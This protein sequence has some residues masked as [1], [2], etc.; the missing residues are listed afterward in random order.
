MYTVRTIIFDLEWSF[1]G[2]S[3]ITT[4][5]VLSLFIRAVIV[6]FICL[7][8]GILA[9][10][11]LWDYVANLQR[12]CRMIYNSE[13]F[14]VNKLE[15]P[16]M[17]R[18]ETAKVKKEMAY[19]PY[20]Y[21]KQKRGMIE[22]TVRLDGSKFHQ[23]GVFTNLTETLEQVYFLSVTDMYERKGYYTYCLLQDSSKSR[24]SIEEVNPVRY[25]IPLTK[26]LTW[27][28]AKIP[29]ALI[30]GGTGGGKSFFLNVLIRGFVKMGADIRI[31]DP[32]NS[33]LS[34][35]KTIL[36][37][38]ATSCTGIMEML[39][40][41]VENMEGRYIEM[42]GNKDYI[43]GQDFTH[44]DL[45][46]MVLIVDEYVAFVDSLDKKDRSI[47]ESYLAQ[48]ALKGREAGVFVVL[49]TQRPDASYLGGGIRDQLGLRVT[50][51]KMSKD[52]YRMTFG[53][54]D[55]KLSNRGGVGRGYVYL[56]GFTFIREFYSPLVPPEYDFIQECANLLGV[57]PCAFVPEVK[58]ASKDDEDQKSP[59]GTYIVEETIMKEVK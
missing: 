29:H 53:Q 30:N 34:D 10:I 22:I 38:V 45:P 11:P 51:G 56:E 37:N 28:I 59:E 47:F 58:K 16:N 32:K 33:A 3:A 1:L 14:L 9:F 2:V 25:E 27:N 23:S 4:N 54:T 13:F 35:Y 42:K 26:D 52:G 20:F 41:A 40:T 21:Y 39:K 55:Q 50:L 7:G 12:L 43:S 8:I 17:M 5:D 46:P 6:G 48:I 44:Y 57:S 15:S 19:F 31:G 49:A 18:A 36:P 24:I